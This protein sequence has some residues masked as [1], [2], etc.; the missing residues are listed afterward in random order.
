MRVSHNCRVDSNSSSE[1]SV[2]QNRQMQHRRD[3]SYI[4]WYTGDQR[5]RRF[6][7]V[8]IY[9]IAYTY[10]AIAVVRAFERVEEVQELDIVMVRGGLGVMETIPISNIGGLIGRIESSDE[11]GKVVYLTSN[12]SGGC[13]M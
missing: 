8:T 4:W 1:L 11:R 5:Q 7:R 6:G 3:N 12:R 2:I 10:E 13:E 9:V